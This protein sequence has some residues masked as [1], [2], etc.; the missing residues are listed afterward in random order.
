MCLLSKEISTFFCE[1]W[2]LMFIFVII[3][4]YIPLAFLNDLIDG[5][6]L[7]FL[8]CIFLLTLEFGMLPAC[9]LVSRKM[10]AW[11]SWCW[12]AYRGQWLGPVS[13]TFILFLRNELC[14]IGAI[15]TTPVLCQPLSLKCCLC[16][17]LIF[18][19]CSQ[20]PPAETVSISIRQ[21][22][23]IVQ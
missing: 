23:R 4:Y 17:H 18:T 10:T 12:F 5:W 15:V 16:F 21:Q 8:S 9:C 14:V 3:S 20:L 1:L 11:I 13:F 7:K 19:T 22:L 6:L 2:V